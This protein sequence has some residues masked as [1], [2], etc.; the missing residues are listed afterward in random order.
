MTAT[1]T[2]TGAAPT[3]YLSTTQL[4]ARYGIARETVWRWVKRGRL[5]EP[6]RMSQRCARWNLR[7]LE[8]SERTSMPDS[9]ATKA[10]AAKLNS[11]SKRRPARKKK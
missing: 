9:R 3:R 5:P 1:K 11:G 4:A 8:D 6:V 10:N 7:E 2:K